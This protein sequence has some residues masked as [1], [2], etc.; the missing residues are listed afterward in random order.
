MIVLRVLLVAVPLLVGALLWFG[1]GSRA[2]LPLSSDRL[3]NYLIERGGGGKPVPTLA[4]RATETAGTP[5][6]A[7]A[8]PAATASSAPPGGSRTVRDVAPGLVPPYASAHA[9]GSSQSASPPR[10]VAANEGSRP[11]GRAAALPPPPAA[12]PPQ[13]ASVQRIGS[14]HTKT[15]AAEAKSTTEATE[16]ERRPPTRTVSL[17]SR[18]RHVAPRRAYEESREEVRR[19]EDQREA[20]E[21]E[22]RDWPYASR[23]LDRSRAERARRMRERYE[24]RGYRTVEQRVLPDGRRMLV[25]EPDD[26]DD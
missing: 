10:V 5:A 17:R 19:W 25:F 3:T 13:P 20:R 1:G 26:T 24:E 2:S 23:S 15:V 16:T 8:A 9:S 18:K 21:T 22:A 6:V 11:P 14:V 12:A 7:A 4:E